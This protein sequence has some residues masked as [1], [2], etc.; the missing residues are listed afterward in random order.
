MSRENP[1][2]GNSPL[3]LAIETSTALLGVA[4]VRGQEVLW[5]ATIVEPRAHSSKL[6]PLCSSA[7]TEVGAGPKDLSAIA[8]SS[9][10]GSFTGLR[11]GFATAQGLAAGAGAGIIPVP[12]FEALLRQSRG[13]P[14]LAIVQ[15]RA[16]AQT[17]TALYTWASAPSVLQGDEFAPRYGYFEV[18]PPAAVGME[19]FLREIPSRVS[20]PVHVA[21]DAAAEFSAYSQAEGRNG[22]KGLELIRVA[23]RARL[24]LPSV[25]GLIASRMFEEGK[26]V[27]PEEAVPRYYRRSQAEVKA[28]QNYPE[29]HIEKMTLEDLDRVLEIEALSYKTP[30]SRRAFTSEVT[31]NSY[32]HYYVCR[33]DGRIIG[34]VGMWVILDEAHITNIAVDPESRRQRVAQ[35][36]LEAMFEKAKESGA[37]RMTLEVRVSNLGAQTLYKKIGFAERGLRKGYYSDTNEDAIIMWKDDLGPQKP[38][39][40]RVKWMV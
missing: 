1:V 4:V 38:K 31:E 39:E 36:L 10:P 37:N 15:G 20:G 13:V 22:P 24:P 32:A 2:W 19:E 8:V 25:V 9:G 27:P 16:K 29:I 6:L 21:G 30:W 5:E 11:I 35:R 40:E 23:D 17:V 18:M 14:T 7:L 28:L 34:Y 33:V 3:I 26:V 12:T